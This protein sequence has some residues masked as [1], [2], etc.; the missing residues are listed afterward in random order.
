VGIVYRSVTPTG[1][2]LQT[3]SIL[4]TLAQGPHPVAALYRGLAP[5][6]LGNA[7]SWASFF[8]FK[9]QA[10]RIIMKF[11]DRHHEPE[12]E[13]SLT[14]AFD[15]AAAPSTSLRPTDY[16]LASAMA[17]AATQLITNPIWVIK[18]RMVSTDAGAAGAYPSMLAGARS[19]FRSEGIAGFY[20]GL[21]V[22]LL[23]VTHGAVQ[24]AVYEPAKRF[25][26]QWRRNRHPSSRSSSLLVGPDDVVTP[27]V[28][29]LD[30]GPERMSNEAT[31]ALSTL[32]K[33]V[34]GATTYPLQV[35]RSRLQ[36]YRTE[37]QFGKGIRGV[38]A[39]LWREEGWRGFYRGLVPGVVRVLPA[40]WVTF[41]VY[42]N[43]KYYLPRT[44][45]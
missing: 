32:A 25:Y 18:T 38:A 26:F 28:P 1:V 23:G 14:P 16:F 39:R 22:G 29:R 31:L 40:T 30:L 5:N 10:E 7:T 20:R 17:G 8:F 37:E 41:L 4:R 43:V 36:T 21:G 27:E 11:K 45:E 19:I 35:M 24:F 12:E 13:L 44:L 9:S 15:P 3:W 42:E 2:P 6:L 34:A 33:L